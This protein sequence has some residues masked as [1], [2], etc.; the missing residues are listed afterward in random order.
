M[1]KE[2]KDA[3]YS[4]LD[5][6]DMLGSMNFI[7]MDIDKANSIRKEVLDVI[8]EKKEVT[9]L[10]SS[11]EDLLGILPVILLDSNKFPSAKEI[12]KFAEKCL[13]IPIRN[14]WLKRSRAEVIGIVINE[15]YEQSP[16]Q[17]NK[18]L[19]AWSKFSNGTDSLSKDDKEH[20]ADSKGFMEAWF[21]FFDS[22]K[23]VD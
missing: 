6:M 7:K 9:I 18:F 5:L 2:T 20:L 8:G 23:G 12:L 15:V 10:D 17:F 1:K 22:Y 14:Y 16:E 11:T 13:N 4:L 3:L 19:R 21:Q